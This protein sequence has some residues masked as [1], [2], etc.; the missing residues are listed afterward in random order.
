MASCTP[1]YGQGFSET[2]FFIFYLP[3]SHSLRPRWGTLGLCCWQGP[4]RHPS[5]NLLTIW[6]WGLKLWDWARCAFHSSL[7]TSAWVSSTPKAPQLFPTYLHPPESSGSE[8]SWVPSICSEMGRVTE[9][10]GVSECDSRRDLMPS[11]QRSH[12]PQTTGD[13]FEWETGQRSICQVSMNTQTPQVDRKQ[14]THTA[15]MRG[16]ASELMGNYLGRAGPGVPGPLKESTGSWWNRALMCLRTCFVLSLGSHSPS[17]SG[18]G[19]ARKQ[20]VPQLWQDH[21]RIVALAINL[22]GV[23]SSC[24][25]FTYFIGVWGPHLF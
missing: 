25:L 2:T 4:E 18:Q 5:Q 22:A 16:S 17:C 11:S 1:I 9:R 8:S 10:Q 20:P 19:S 15:F 13:S 14:R 23:T 6:V 12:L 3:N 21:V 24:L 7:L